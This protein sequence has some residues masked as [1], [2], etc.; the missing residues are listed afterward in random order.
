MKGYFDILAPVYEKLHIGAQTTFR[1][2]TDAIRFGP[3]DVVIDIGGGTGRIA[4]FFVSKVRKIIVI[5]PSEKMVEQCKKH[6]GITCVVAR[7]E[8][9]P[10]PD[11]SAD[12]IILI[13]AFHHISDQPGAMREMKR[14]LAKN[15]QIVMEEFD[16]LTIGGKFV[17]LLE[18]ILRMGSVFY[19]PKDLAKLFT[20]IGFHAWI[21]D[22]KKKNYYMI[23]QHQGDNDS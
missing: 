11:A 5:D 2:I 13:D 8:K 12:K 10:L 4:Q 21:I 15:G 9:L 7:A 17:I 1:A 14:I 23:A 22:G 16:P 18:N 20:D 3:A 6:P 19:A